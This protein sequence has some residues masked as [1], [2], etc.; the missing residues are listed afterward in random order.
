MSDAAKISVEIEAVTGAA[1][2][3]L[4]EAAGCVKEF[5]AQVSKQMEGMQK[6]L[7]LSTLAHS[8]GHI[9][10]ALA[11]LKRQ[12][13][14]CVGAAMSWEQ[15]VKGLSR[16]L[17]VSTKEAGG[18]AN[19]LGRLGADTGA[20][21]GA[22]FN[23]Q[24]ALRGQEDAFN[25]NGIATRDANGEMLGIQ[26]VMMNSIARLREMKPGY[27]ANALATLAFGRSAKDLGGILN[28]TN[29]AIEDGAEKVNALGVEVG[30]GDTAAQAYKAAMADVNDTLEAL[31]IRMG[32]ELMPA[33]AQLAQT[34]SSIANAVAP[35][36]AACFKTLAA[37]TDHW[38]TAL[39][40]L[41]VVLAN[42][43]K[44]AMVELFT[45]VIPKL[46]AG[47]QAFVASL[48]PIGIAMAVVAAAVVVWD[49]LGNS[50]KRAAKAA[51]DAATEAA[52]ARAGAAGQLLQY[53]ADLREVIG[54]MAAEEKAGKK[55]TAAQEERRQALV[56]AMEAL[57][58]AGHA[59]AYYM[60][61]L[62]ASEIQ[63]TGLI[64]KMLEMQKDITVRALAG[65]EAELAA[66]KKTD[67]GYKEKADTVAELRRALI[68]LTGDA[69]RAAGAFVAPGGGQP[70]PPKPPKPTK[71]AKDE[72]NL[73]EPS[74]PK[75]WPGTTPPCGTI[76]WPSWM[77]SA[78][79]PTTWSTWAR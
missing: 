13:L 23:L 37:V 72:W 36:L 49:Q 34:F 61:A 65:A 20:Y 43:L 24:Q 25:A 2:A 7:S 30:A 45:T 57:G 38:K 32:Q 68:A 3:A 19:A 21:R 44:V 6:S 17:G 79:R 42:K 46:I 33:V 11:G 35:A 51:A 50:A 58:G 10:D 28:L 47:V 41:V 59:H 40:A 1:M 22:V 29:E 26:Q 66:T 70:P 73:P 12:I 62:S 48:G 8:L 76:A 55:A 74:W 54:Q 5:A 4:N 18:L 71:P 64:D 52:R 31:K 15:S 39:A 67:D 53:A 27:D 63:R 69:V 56:R 78:R 9:K 60:G 16:T 77:T 14:D 75:S